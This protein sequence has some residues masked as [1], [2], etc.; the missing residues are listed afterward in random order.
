MKFVEEINK[1]P[2]KTKKFQNIWVTIDDI[3]NRIHYNAL[4]NQILIEILHIRIRNILETILSF[5]PYVNFVPFMIC[6][7]DNAE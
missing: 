1:F 6:L 3:D 4:L 5:E 2:L 7:E